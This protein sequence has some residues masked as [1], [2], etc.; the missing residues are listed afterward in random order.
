MDRTG[1]QRVER[2]RL[3]LLPPRLARE[4][5]QGPAWPAAALRR[6]PRVLATA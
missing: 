1:S 4:D 5:E 3:D 6:L 2:V